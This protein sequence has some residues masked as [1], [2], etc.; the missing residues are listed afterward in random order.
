DLV[1]YTEFHQ[2]LKEYALAGKEAGRSAEELADA[3]EPPANMSDFS[4]GGPL[5]GAFVQL[6]HDESETR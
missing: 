5:L 6:I 1:R 4:L 2:H 3:Y